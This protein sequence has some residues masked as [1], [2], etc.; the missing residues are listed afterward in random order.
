MQEMVQT[1]LAFIF[2]HILKG[3]RGENVARKYRYIDFEDRKRIARLWSI[4]TPAQAI[5]EEIGTDPATISRELRRGYPGKDG[6][7]KRPAY[8]PVIAQKAV[9]AGIARR[10]KKRTQAVAL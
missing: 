7:N 2:L 8:N 9:E 4:G 10:G 3:K 6:R 5:A 1:I